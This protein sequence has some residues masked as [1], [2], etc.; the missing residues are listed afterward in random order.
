MQTRQARGYGEPRAVTRGAARGSGLTGLTT[1]SPAA[2]PD[3][4]SA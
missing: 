3:G 2:L 4:G 1:E